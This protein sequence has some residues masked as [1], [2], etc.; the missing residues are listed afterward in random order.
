MAANAFR[1]PVETVF[2]RFSIQLSSPPP[3]NFQ[4]SLLAQHSLGLFPPD[5]KCNDTQTAST[6]ADVLP[7]AR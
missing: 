4:K 5:T 1:L 7:A 6:K 3:I 2:Y